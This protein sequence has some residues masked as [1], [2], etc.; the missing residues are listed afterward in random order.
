MS[1]QDLRTALIEARDALI[2]LMDAMR[3][4]KLV[5]REESNTLTRPRIELPLWRLQNALDDIERA[6]QSLERVD[7]QDS[8]RFATLIQAPFGS[9]GLG[10]RSSSDVERSPVGP[11]G[12]T[13]AGQA[14]GSRQ[15]RGR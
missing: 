3:S 6:L 13:S 1:D 8:H 12:T 2:R 14:H 5:V 7:I 15:D 9:G 4:G 11:D 10:E